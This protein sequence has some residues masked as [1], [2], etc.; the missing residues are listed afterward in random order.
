MPET[1]NAVREY[2]RRQKERGLL[3]VEVQAS[4]PDAGLLRSTAR[5]LRSGSAEAARVRRLLREVL[6]PET[7]GT[8]L[9]E[10]LEAAPLEGV[11]LSRRS[12]RPRDVEL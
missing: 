11:D 1:G 12:D 5:L 4:E 2:R 8:G 3:R 6:G 9:K 10:L 7:E